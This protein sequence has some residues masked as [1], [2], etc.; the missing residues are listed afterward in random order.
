MNVKELSEKINKVLKKYNKTNECYIS[1]IE[2]TPVDISTRDE[3]LVKYRVVI[4]AK[5]YEN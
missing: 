4:K 5:L 2:I 3:Q 1:D